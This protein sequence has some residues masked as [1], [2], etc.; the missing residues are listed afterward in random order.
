MERPVQF[1]ADEQL[2]RAKDMSPEEIA[3]FLDDFRR[4]HGDHST[5]K[6]R[7]I[8]LKVPEDLLRA[9]KGKARLEG[10]RYQTQIKALMR[11][12]LSRRPRP[13]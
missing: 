9:F 10:V 11:D 3:R 6:S 5:S 7:L 12:W 13:E 2:E 4:L 1:F 8:S